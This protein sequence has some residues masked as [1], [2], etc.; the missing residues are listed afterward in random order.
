VAITIKTL[1]IIG[2]AEIAGVGTGVAEA[3]E[4]ARIIGIAEIEVKAGTGVSLG[5][6]VFSFYA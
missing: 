1:K 5:I 4:I 2:I 3:M 6:K